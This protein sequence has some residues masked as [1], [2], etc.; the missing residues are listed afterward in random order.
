MR[1]GLKID[2]AGYH[3]RPVT[4]AVHIMTNPEGKEYRV[5]LGML[6]CECPS[7]RYGRRQCK[8]LEFVAAFCELL[9]GVS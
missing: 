1:R 2:A 4:D 5:D 8:H 7:F 6:E 3:V 9:E